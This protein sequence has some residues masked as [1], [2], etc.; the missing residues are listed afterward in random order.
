MGYFTFYFIIGTCVLSCLSQA[1]NEFHKTEA[2]IRPNTT[3]SGDYSR[4]PHGLRARRAAR[5]ILS[6]AYIV[7]STREDLYAAGNGFAYDRDRRRVFTW[8]PRNHVSNGRWRVESE[9]GLYYFFN[10]ANS[11]YLY[12]PNE[13][14]SKTFYTCFGLT[15]LEKKRYLFTWRKGNRVDS[16]GWILSKHIASGAYYIKNYKYGGYLELNGVVN[17]KDRREVF[18]GKD[19][20]NLWYVNSC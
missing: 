14:F 11:E 19:P 13:H 18:L 4:L 1:F 16:A 12:S 5:V 3:G 10:L 17:V 7:S 6:C 8:T 9:N 2:G 15:C 20:I